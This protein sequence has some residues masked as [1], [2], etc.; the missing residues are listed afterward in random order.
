MNTPIKTELIGS[1]TGVWK[2]ITETSTYI[3]D[4]DSGTGRRIPGEGAGAL[5]GREVV[6]NPLAGD[7][8]WFPIVSMFCSLGET[9]YIT[10]RGVHDWKISTIVREIVSVPADEYGYFAE[11]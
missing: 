2:V 6:V 11:E 7:L 5:P 4:L 8:K 1:D 10:S 9:M 3:F